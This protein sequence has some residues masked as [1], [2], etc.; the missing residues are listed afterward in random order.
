MTIRE[1]QSDLSSHGQTAALIMNNNLQQDNIISSIC[2]LQKQQ[3]DG[4][5]SC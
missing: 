3:T 2:E 5:E 4:D 1:V